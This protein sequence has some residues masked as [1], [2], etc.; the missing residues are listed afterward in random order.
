MQVG[1]FAGLVDIG[2]G[3]KIFLECRGAGAPTVIFESGYR[4]AADI[5]STQGE[6]SSAAVFPEVAKYTRVCAYDRPGTLLD[7]DR[8][9]RSDPVKMPRTAQD[10]VF[11][12]HMLPE[13]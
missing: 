5:W 1:D 12:L 3:R 6:S 10:L 11:D 13:S 2:N 4:T 8:L 7:T 9:G